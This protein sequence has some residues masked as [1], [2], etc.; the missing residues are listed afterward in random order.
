M[1][2]NYLDDLIQELLANHVVSS[3]KV[4]K[5]T[6]GEEDGYIRI[7]ERVINVAYR[8]V[9]SWSLLNTSKFV[10]IKFILRPITFIGRPQTVN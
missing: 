9:T 1:V 5:R 4:L 7:K 2:E 6:D 10:K 8:M 3:F